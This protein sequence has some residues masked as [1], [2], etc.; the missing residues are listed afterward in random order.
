VDVGCQERLQRSVVYQPQ[1]DIKDREGVQGL[2]IIQALG[3][4]IAIVGSVARLG[5][6]WYLWMEREGQGQ[7]GTEIGQSKGQ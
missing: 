2:G 7:M 4:E 1:G 5:G 6:G 3:T